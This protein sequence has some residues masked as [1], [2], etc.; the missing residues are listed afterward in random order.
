MDETNI[1]L[2][3]LEALQS[4][5]SLEWLEGLE[6]LEGL[7]W[8]QA[9]DYWN[10]FNPDVGNTL[11]LIDM[12]LNIFTLLSF[13]WMWYGIYVLAKKMWVKHAWMWW[14]PLVQYYTLCKVAGV[15][16][17]KHMVLP[18][19]ILVWIALVA[20][21][22]AWLWFIWSKWGVW[23]NILL[24]WMIVGFSYLGAYIFS[25]V[26]YFW[27]LSPISKK[28]WRWG[29]TTAGLFFFP[30]IMFPVVAYKYKKWENSDELI[31]T[32]KEVDEK[33]MTDKKVEL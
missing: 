15:W 24:S 5:E 11:N 10:T 33:D 17:F 9:L 6:S 4:L 26:R 16:F 23:L 32:V 27:I 18:F 2:D 14:V 22:I 1:S 30:F 31:N 28:T 19:L 25:I 3:Q 20:L 7:D 13:I 29:W 8:M 21:I 12:W